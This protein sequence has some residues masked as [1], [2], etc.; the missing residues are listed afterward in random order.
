MM[1]CSTFVVAEAPEGL[2][3]I[4]GY[5]DEKGE[6]KCY[7]EPCFTIHKGTEAA[8]SRDRPFSSRDWTPRRAKNPIH[9]FWLRRVLSKLAMLKK[10]TVFSLLKANGLTLI[11]EKSLVK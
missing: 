11:A 6:Y 8:A 10:E 2:D 5:T 7:A 1:L 9:K 4:G 3:F